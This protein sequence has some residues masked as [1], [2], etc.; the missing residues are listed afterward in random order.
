MFAPGH[1]DLMKKHA[2]FALLVTTLASAAPLDTQKT[3]TPPDA[4]AGTWTALPGTKGEPQNTL[5]T[6]ESDGYRLH[7]R[8]YEAS[9]FQEVS[10]GV[11]E[12]ASLGTIRRGKLTLTGVPGET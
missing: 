7:R 8:P 6:K 10:P 2:I 3:S 9:R 5:I 11:L 1:E 4:W 12:C